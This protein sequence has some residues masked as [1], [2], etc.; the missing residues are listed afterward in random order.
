MDLDQKEIDVF[1]QVIYHK[2][3]SVLFSTSTPPPGVS[4]LKILGYSQDDPVVEPIGFGEPIGMITQ[5]PDWHVAYSRIYEK[6]TKDPYTADDLNTV[7]TLF[8]DYANN[9]LQLNDSQIVSIYEWDYFPHVSVDSIAQ[10]WFHGARQLQGYR[11]TYWTSGLYSFEDINS[12]FQ[13]SKQL[14]KRFF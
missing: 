10:G 8:T 3:M 2:Y 13:A 4:Y 5:S 14:I 1:S 9:V 6:D 11:S 12:A 7:T